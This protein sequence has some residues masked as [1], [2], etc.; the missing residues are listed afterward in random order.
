M[1]AIASIDADLAEVVRSA[2][3]GDQRAWKNLTDRFGRMIL[4]IARS[5]RLNEA[6]A[7]DV[8]QTT[9][10]RLVENIDR[11]EQPQRIGGWLV[12]TSK[13]ESLR[14]VRKRARFTLD[15][16]AIV[17]LV[18]ASAP[19]LDAGPLADERSAV[20]RAA[21]AQLPPRCQ[22][23][24]GILGGADP[25]SYKQVSEAFAMPIGSIGPTRGRCLEHLRRIIFEMGADI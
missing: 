23:L 15:S 20:V 19:A 1:T 8:H 6:D 21:F 24:L 10:L 17:N 16:E 5:Y 2:A 12:T 14:L 4:G 22:Q 13:H 25:P 11:I 7:A 3:A 9:W 18:D